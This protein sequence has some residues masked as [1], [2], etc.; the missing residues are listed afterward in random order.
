MVKS[1]NHSITGM[2]NQM[3]LQVYLWTVSFSP[4]RSMQAVAGVHS[5][6]VGI[7]GLLFLGMELK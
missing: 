6:G 3:N 7:Q 1:L 2:P 4:Q 5:A